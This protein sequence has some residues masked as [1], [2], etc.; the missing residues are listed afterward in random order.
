MVCYLVEGV[1]GLK[2][3]DL[4]G[5]GEMGKK[6]KWRIGTFIKIVRGKNA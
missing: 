4:V 2:L 1:E 5:I 3:E 6:G